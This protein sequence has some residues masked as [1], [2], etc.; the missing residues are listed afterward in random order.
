MIELVCIG[1]GC[2]DDHPCGGQWSP[3]SWVRQD[4]LAGVGVCSGCPASEEARFDCGDRELSEAAA[5]HRAELSAEIE[6]EIDGDDR[7]LILP[8]DFAYD[9]TLNELRRR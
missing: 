9:E 4:P 2:T 1:C 7:D 5:E 8:G 6:Q 3:C